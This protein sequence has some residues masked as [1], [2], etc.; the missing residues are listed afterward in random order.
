MVA[1]IL[2]YIYATDPLYLDAKVLFVITKP[3]EDWKS[4]ERKETEKKL[5][6]F[7]FQ[8]LLNF[9]KSKLPENSLNL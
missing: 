1:A 5:T 2:P 7:F 9:E 8:K 6:C 4:K 3:I